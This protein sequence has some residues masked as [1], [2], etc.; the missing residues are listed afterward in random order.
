MRNRTMT[1]LKHFDWTKVP[2]P[3]ECAKLRLVVA[4]NMVEAY[5]E[6]LGDRFEIVPLSTTRL[7]E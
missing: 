5:R 4:D 1:D 3:E 2:L 6:Q 7:P